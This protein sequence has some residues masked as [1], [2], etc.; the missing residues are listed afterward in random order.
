[1]QGLVRC[2]WHHPHPPC[3]DRQRRVLSLGGLRPDRWQ[4]IPAPED[5][6][7]HPSPQREGGALSADPGR[8]TALRPTL[9]QRG[10]SLSCD[11]GLEHPLQLPP[12]TLRRGR[13]ATG[14]P[15]VGRRHQRPALIHLDVSKGQ[16]HCAPTPEQ[17][18]LRIFVPVITGTSHPSVETPV[19]GPVTPDR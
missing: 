8:R 12:T 6:A 18:H 11:R 14:I 10:S 1:S 2:P 13:S 7:L 15:T 5:Q 16:R 9:H 4:S 19:R 3:R 17:P